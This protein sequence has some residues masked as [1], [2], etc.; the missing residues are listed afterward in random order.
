MKLS[1][2]LVILDIES[3]GTWVEKDR[4]IEIAL[5]KYHPD[6]K[7][8]IFEKRIN[9]GM[10]IPPF[11]TQLTGISD[12]DVKEALPFKSYAQTIVDFIGAADM[13]GFNIERFDLPFLERECADAGVRFEWKQRKIYDA[14]KV[15]HLNEKRD[16]SAAYQF[17]CGQNLIGAHSARADSEAVFS[18]LEKQVEKYGAGSD[19]LTALDQ[20]EYSS[21]T[22][23]FDSERKFCWWD[24]KLYLM[25]GKYA[26]K[27]SLEEIVKTD[28][29]YLNW[30]LKSDFSDNVKKI[31]RAAMKGDIPVRSP[32]SA[33]AATN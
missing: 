24:G 17:Y 7:K 30:I 5:I 12:A 23:F 6:G 33:V 20:F 22:D 21:G 29:G 15:F 10:P 14:Q 3:T 16:L 8:E 1:N 25:F 13:G 32:G 11:V 18:I 2:A 4:I 9:P 26:R 19:A 27:L 31:I 28:S